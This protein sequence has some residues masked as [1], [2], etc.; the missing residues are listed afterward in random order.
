MHRPGDQRRHHENRQWL[1]G[2]RR[3]QL[4]RLG[5]HGA[6][7]DRL[8]KQMQRQQDKPETDGRPPQI[9]RPRPRSG[10]EDDQPHEDKGWKYD[11]D[12]EGQCPDDQRRPDVAPSITAIAG[13]RPITPS[14]RNDVAIIPVAVLLCNASVTPTP[15]RHAA[16]RL[17]SVRPSNWRRPP[18]KARRMPVRTIWTPQS[19]R[20]TSPRSSINAWVAGI[21]PIILTPVPGYGSL[22]INSDTT[23]RA[24]P[25]QRQSANINKTVNQPQGCWPSSKHPRPSRPCEGWYRPS[26]PGQDRCHAS[27]QTADR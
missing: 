18:P 4:P 16:N 14:A 6:R 1:P 25:V 8:D 19:S 24:V 20:A 5:R 27:E 26:C 23:V 22:F 9:A 3:N 12:V 15:A 21:A 11:G 10:T 2:D 17:R 13:I 7:H